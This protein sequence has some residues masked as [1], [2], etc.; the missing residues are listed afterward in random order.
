[1]LEESKNVSG[2][3]SVKPS[4]RPPFKRRIILIK[5]S[6][7][8]KYAAVMFILF[9]LAAFTVWW[10]VYQSLSGLSD[11]GLITDPNLMTMVT[12]ISTVVFMKVG[13]LLILVW[14]LSIALS[15]FVAGPIYR[16]E[17]SL[18]TLRTG[19][20]TH[21]VFLRKRDELKN[22]AQEFNDTIN[23][24]QTNVLNDRKKIEGL[25]ARLQGLA[26]K[27]DSA[28]L[29]SIIAELKSVTASFKA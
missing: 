16:F 19:D 17:T 29:Q 15:H 25:A 27:V 22:L 11:S 12:K 1:M 8:M 24:L 13:A 26:G 9:A 3:V 7:Q 28:E 10:E 5:R 21:R 18:K 14:I 6:L 20:L 2:E 4:V 23:V